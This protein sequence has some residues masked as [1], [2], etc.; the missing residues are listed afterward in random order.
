MLQKR[1]KEL[2]E[3]KGLS[4]MFTIDAERDHAPHGETYQGM[5]MLP[6]ALDFCDDHAI[7]ATIF[8]TGD[9]ARK[10]PDILKEAIKNHEIGCHMDNHEPLIPNAYDQQQL[11]QSRLEKALAAATEALNALKNPHSFRAPYLAFDYKVVP[12]LIQHGYSISS[13]VAASHSQGLVAR[14]EIT[15]ICVSASL[16]VTPQLRYDVFSLENMILKGDS[17]LRGLF[18]LLILKYS[19][20]PL[21]PVVFLCHSWELTPSTLSIIEPMLETFPDTMRFQTMSEFSQIL[22]ESFKTLS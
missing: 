1:E 5:T 13:S 17:L 15:E 20:V 12:A 2:L 9:V 21:L 4:F 6:H 16:S 10:F 22:H 8:C 11:S 7:P 19:T 14:G 18:D 3:E